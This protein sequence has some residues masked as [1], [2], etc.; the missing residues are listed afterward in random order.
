MGFNDGPFGLGE[1]KLLA[2]YNN[3]FARRA[4]AEARVEE[5]E[6]QL[7]HVT[8]ALCDADDMMMAILRKRE[9]T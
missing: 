9:T 2:D 6:A 5:L 1:D 4:V 3:E 7:K 8:E